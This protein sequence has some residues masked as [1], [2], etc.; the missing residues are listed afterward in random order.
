M[1]RHRGV[2]RGT[3]IPTRLDARGYAQF[4]VFEQ[5]LDPAGFTFGKSE[6]E[7]H[8]QIWHRTRFSQIGKFHL[9]EINFKGDQIYGAI[10]A[11]RQVR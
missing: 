5:S 9:A 4:I 3:V 2:K 11:T 1:T 6:L 7:E 8:G 10:R